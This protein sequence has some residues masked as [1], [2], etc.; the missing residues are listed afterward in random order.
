[1]KK[2]LAIL[3]S[4]I[5]SSN[6]QAAPVIHFSAQI[7]DESLAE[8]VILLLHCVSTRSGLT[9]EFSGETKA[10]HTLLARE[11]GRKARLAWKQPGTEKQ[12]VMSKGGS[13]EACNALAPALA[14]PE[15]GAPGPNTLPALSSLGSLEEDTE[16]TPASK[17]WIW[18]GLGAAAVAGF[19]IWRSRQPDHHG[20]ELH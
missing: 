15:T 6:A 9:W 7:D 1:M 2:Q 13:E 17:A 3:L 14:E 16:E 4:L 12:T 19:L 10:S 11:E 5:L 20:V 8:D 18:A